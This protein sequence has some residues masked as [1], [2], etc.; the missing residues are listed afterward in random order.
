MA[1]DS[2]TIAIL[3]LLVSIVALTISAWGAWQSSV[4]A[5]HSR[6]LAYLDEVAVLAL[7]LRERRDILRRNAETA[8]KICAVAPAPLK[9]R[10]AVLLEQYD[11]MA[12]DVD[13]LFKTAKT[14]TRGTAAVAHEQQLSLRRISSSHRIMLAETK[15]IDADLAKFLILAKA[16]YGLLLDQE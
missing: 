16:D 13:R 2:D 9:D 11:T 1:M 10:V 4:A 7:E 12:S 6:S 15:S 8:K 5:R 3:S 14:L